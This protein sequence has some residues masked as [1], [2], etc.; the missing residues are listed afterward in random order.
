VAAYLWLFA[1]WVNHFWSFN[2]HGSNFLFMAVEYLPRYI[3]SLSSHCIQ[4]HFF[5]QDVLFAPL[6]I[7]VFDI[8]MDYAQ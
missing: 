1:I 6:G 7:F 3:L 8:N 5:A 4:H 2:Q